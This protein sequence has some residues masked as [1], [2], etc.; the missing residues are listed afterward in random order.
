MSNLIRNNQSIHKIPGWMI[1]I[2]TKNLKVYT[3]LIYTKESREDTI[4][5]VIE[6]F[7]QSHPFQKIIKVSS[8]QL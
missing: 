7:H 3:E 1:S 6:D 2:K 4:L 8:I 5:K